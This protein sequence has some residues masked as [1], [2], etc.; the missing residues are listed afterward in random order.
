MKIFPKSIINK[1]E[2]KKEEIPFCKIFFETSNTIDNKLIHPCKCDGSIKFVHE[3]CILKWINQTDNQKTKCE[4]CHYEYKLKKGHNDEFYFFHKG[5]TSCRTEVLLYI[6][7]ILSCSFLATIYGIV[8]T[9]DN[10]SWTEFVSNNNTIAVSSVKFLYEINGTSYG[11]TILYYFPMGIYSVNICFLLFFISLPLMKVNQYKLY[12]KL[13]YKHYLILFNFLNVYL[14]L[15]LGVLQRAPINDF[16]Y[17]FLYINI[18][19]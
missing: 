19:I 4:I 8:D 2:Q 17:F 5:P 7:Y 13:I 18:M 6:L 14:Y 3:K 11:W 1:I 9:T 16:F 15:M 10:Y 12:Y